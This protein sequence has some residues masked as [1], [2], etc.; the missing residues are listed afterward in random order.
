MKLVPLCTLL[1]CV[2]CASGERAITVSPAP[3]LLSATP[4]P[5]LP[6][7]VPPL[8]LRLSAQFTIMA[9]GHVARVL[10]LTSSGSPGWDSLAALAMTDWRFSSAAPGDSAANRVVRCPIVVQ[11]GVRGSPIMR[12]G[13][14]P[15]ATVRE[16]DSLYALLKSGADFDSLAHAASLR[17]LPGRDGYIRTVDLGSFPPDVRERV[18]GLRDEEYTAPVRV[19]AGYVIFRRY[20]SADGHRVSRESAGFLRGAVRPPA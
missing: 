4:L 13:E 8:G 20:P 15:A 11:P 7:S 1:V 3:H 19:D 6:A 5:E 10:L 12:L 17:A 2:G 16:A 14:L 18:R 9:D